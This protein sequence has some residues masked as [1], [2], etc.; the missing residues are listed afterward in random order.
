M[1][2]VMV[3]II[4]YLAITYAYPMLVTYKMSVWTVIRNSL[5]LAVGRL[6]QS[7]G[8]RLLHCVPMVWAR[9]RLEMAF[10]SAGVKFIL[11]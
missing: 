8:I 9:P 11:K 5:I 3:G 1:I 7:I 2:P 4:W 10:T 6:P